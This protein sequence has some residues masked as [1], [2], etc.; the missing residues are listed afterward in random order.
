MHRLILAAL[1]L[2]AP[3]AWAQPLPVPGGP[4][5]AGSVTVLYTYGNATGVCNGADTSEDTLFTYNI[6]AGTLNAA[7]DRIRIYAGG[8]FAGSTDTKTARVHLNG[9][10]FTHNN[11]G[12]AAV[13]TA[14][15]T[16]VEVQKIGPSLQQASSFGLGNAAS[17]GVGAASASLTDTAAI[18]LTVTGQNATA[19][20]AGSIC[21]R[22]VAVEYQT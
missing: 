19:A 20:T 4:G 8:T 6:P 18:A 1:L 9:A 2:T 14:W 17:S 15:V 5:S 16:Y 12:V 21:V 11:N 10:G 3:Q 22:Y 7:G 13:T